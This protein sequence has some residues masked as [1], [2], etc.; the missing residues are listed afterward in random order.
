[1]A[2][3]LVYPERCPICDTDNYILRVPH[4]KNTDMFSR[5]FCC[6]CGFVEYKNSLEEP[7]IAGVSNE[8][9]F[10]EIRFKYFISDIRQFL[11][12]IPSWNGVWD[13][14]KAGKFMT[15]HE[16]EY[17]EILYKLPNIPEDYRNP[18]GSVNQK[19]RPDRRN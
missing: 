5:Y 4:D 1:M 18:D 17:W 11:K 16:K 3:A 9:G 7:Y 13:G 14:S 12:Q 10:P 19:Y 15:E 2:K 6:Y 8:Y